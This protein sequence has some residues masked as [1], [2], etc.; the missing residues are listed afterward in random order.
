MTNDTGC[1]FFIAKYFFNR[2]RQGTIARIII[3]EVYASFVLQCTVFGLKSKHK[4][5]VEA[6]HG[7][8]LSQKY[9]MEH[10]GHRKLLCELSK[11]SKLNA[12]NN[13]GY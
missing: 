12:L 9:S 2:Q 8:H 13:L 10:F 7:I 5:D 11:L 6:L 3:S 4:T 1:I